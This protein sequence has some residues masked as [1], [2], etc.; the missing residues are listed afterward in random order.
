MGLEER[1]GEQGPGKMNKKGVPCG[2]YE[3]IYAI[4]LLINPICCFRCL[5]SS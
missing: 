4:L 3:V 1:V 5:Y 2:F